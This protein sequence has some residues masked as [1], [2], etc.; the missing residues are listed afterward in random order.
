MT[1]V[2]LV[3]PTQRDAAAHV[4]LR[5][6]A[7]E[8]TSYSPQGRVVGMDDTMLRGKGIQQLAATCALCNDAEIGYDAGTY[9]RVGEP[10]EAALKVLVEKMG[11]YGAPPPADAAAA[12]SHYCSLLSAGFSRQATLEFSRSRKSMSVLCR[13]LGGRLNSLFVKGAPETVLPRCSRVRLADGAVVPMTDAWRNRLT[14]QFDGMASRP[15]RCLALAVKEGKELG[16]LATYR[17]EAPRPAQDRLL[18]DPSRFEGIESGMTF[19]GLV[20]IKDPA[21]PEVAGAIESC[22]QAGIR[23]VMIT[24]DSAQTATAIAREV[25]ILNA[26]ATAAEAQGLTFVPSDFFDLDQATQVLPCV[27]ILP[28]SFHALPP[29]PSLIP[30]L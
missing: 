15:L 27:S 11:L 10:T 24:G 7:V 4:A 17:D 21:R 5:E 30:L 13:P 9:T 19:V 2:S 26:S 18:R 29:L 12:A 16:P 8:G 25:G 3:V 1:V 20:G 14:E 6:Y 23:V 22:R 28:L